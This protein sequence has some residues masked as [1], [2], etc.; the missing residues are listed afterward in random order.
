MN[1]LNDRQS[2]KDEIERQLVIEESKKINLNED[3]VY[4]FLKHIS[5]KPINDLNKKRSL[6]NI[7]VHS[8][9]LYDDHFNIILNG[10]N[11]Q[12]SINDIPIKSINKALKRDNNAESST[13]EDSVPPKN[14]RIY[15]N[16]LIFTRK[17]NRKKIRLN[18]CVY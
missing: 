15:K 2:E 12:L 3:Q 18:F 9:Y 13:I 14:N 4:A 11:K 17:F 5:S 6:I 7:F 8:V 16:T 1:R 10:S